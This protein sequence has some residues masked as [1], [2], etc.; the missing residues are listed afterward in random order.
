VHRIERVDI[1]RVERVK[2][3]AP[4]LNAY[5]KT[6]KEGE[7]IRPV[8]N[9][10]QAPSYKIAKFLNKKFLCLIDMPDMFNDKNS[11]EVA[12]DLQDI[13]VNDNHKTITLDIKD[14]Y[15]NLPTRNI[16]NITK[17]WLKTINQNQT[18]I[19][20]ILYLLKIILEQNYFQHEDNFYKPNKGIAMGPPISNTLAEI[21]LQFFERI[22]LK[23]YLETKNII[24]YKRY[25]DDLIIIY[26]HTKINADTIHDI[27]NST[28]VHLE[29]KLTKEKNHITN[30]LDLSIQRKHNEFQLNIYRK[31]TC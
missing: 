21:Y 30:Y 1:M 19:G 12:R 7:P 15:V 22:Y 6:H 17:F 29:F 4:L 8:I 14:L 31:P 24:Y 26:D 10:T 18:I 11:Q 3:T 25:V 16:V 20:K 13:P 9:N 27:I 28:D 23:H 5:V 2:P